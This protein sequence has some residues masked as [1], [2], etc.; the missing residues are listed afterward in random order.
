MLQSH[1]VLRRYTPPTCTL[2]IMAENSPL[3]RWAGQPV[4]KNLHFQLSLD[5]PKLAEEKQITVKGDRPQLEALCEAVT[6]YVQNLLEQPTSSLTIHPQAAESN[7]SLALM[8]APIHPPTPSALEA[9]ETGVSLQS[10]GLL[11]HELAL[12][13]LATE[14]SGPTV[15]LSTLQLFDLAN[16]LDEYSTDILNLPALQSSRR[17]GFAGNWA[18]IAAVAL[19]AVGLST[20]A[21]KLLDGS[22]RQF[23]QVPASSEGASS[24][25]QKIA[26]QLSPAVVDQA[27]PPVSSADRL[28]P[29]PPAGS[30]MPT[31]PGGPPTIITPKTV[32]P[33]P[34]PGKLPSDAISS[35]PVP[36]PGRPTIIGQP[37]EPLTGEA[38]GKPQSPQSIAIAPAPTAADSASR[39][40]PNSN[41]QQARRSALLKE[42]AENAPNTAFDTI[43]QVAEA[44]DYFKQRWKPVEGLTQTLEYSLVVNANGTIQN[45]TPLKQASGDYIDRTGMPLLGDPFVSP[46][47][48]GKTAKIRLVLEPDGKVQTFLEGL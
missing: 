27:T 35:Y 6:A 30:L 33:S 9:A 13:N 18:Q 32:A 21:I 48:D 41:T 23:A 36:V 19:L 10:K 47:K 45:I 37:V 38:A 5:D 8:D 12:G 24:A 44:R 40:A 1:S 42:S 25:D 4:V 2:A 46:I 29:P 26:T 28:P 15:S 34:S 7:S 16:A 39:S 11:Q 17:F 43:P 20:S 3:S 31:K 14:E 22:H